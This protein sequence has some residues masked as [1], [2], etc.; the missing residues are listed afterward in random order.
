[1]QPTDPYAEIMKKYGYTPPA[2][3]GQ[4]VSS[5][6]DFDNFVN[7]KGSY[8]P[9]PAPTNPISET[10]QNYMDSVAPAAAD[11]Q[12]GGNIGSAADKLGKGD[13]AGGVED[14]TLGAGSDAV[15]A[16]FAPISAPLQTLMSHVGSANANN[17]SPTANVVNSPEA[18][19]AHKQITDWVT[20]LSQD[21][22]Q[23]VKTLGDAFN[24]GAA[25][26][27]SG[28]L[29]TTVSDA[30]SAVK[31][32]V[33]D[34]TSATKNAIVGSPEA[35][36]QATKAADLNTIADTI[37]PKPTAAQAKQTLDQGRLYKGSEPGLFRE[38]TP[39]K[40]S[41]TEQQAN[42][43]RTIHELIPDA[44][45]MN[46]ADLHGAL[47]EKI[48]E[49]AQK[50]QPKM[51]STPIQP[52]TIQNINDNWQN[53]KKTQL[54]EAKATDEPNI[55]KWQN[56]FEKFLKKS[57]NENLNDLWES[58][59]KYDASIKSN[60][61]TATGLSPE[62]LQTQKDIWLQNRAVLRD[63]IN[64]ASSGLGKTSQTAF[65]QMKDMYEA[66]NGI[67]S[68]A[69]IVTEGAPSKVSQFIKSPKGKALKLGAEE[70]GRAHV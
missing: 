41:L 10:G 52:D 43:A 59:K 16:I 22:P 53:L 68:K 44:A 15:K 62:D 13:I 45:K 6:D 61:K 21:H 60:V 32:S 49:V 9:P 50:L 23:L 25:A 63:A 39:D 57:G 17:P 65:S 58:A 30:A 64:D 2:S 8:A 55:I 37:T 11:I 56:N 29:D 51:E 36:A 46:D 70:I 1:M 20:Q 3:S 24:I 34:A 47:D 66:Q 40:V 69:K 42:S 28:A 4:P 67:M 18:Q 33:T 35:A 7:K 12:G 54:A 38:G 5:A 27:G 19:A 48:T 31:N 14:A 26:L